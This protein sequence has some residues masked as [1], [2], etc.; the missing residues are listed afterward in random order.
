METTEQLRLEAFFRSLDPEWRTQCQGAEP[1]EI[2][3]LEGAAQ[4]P[5]PGFYRWFLTRMGASMGSFYYRT[6]DFTVPTL[7]AS[8]EE[9]EVERSDRFLL[10]ARSFAP[11]LSLH[12]FYDFDWRTG[13]DARVVVAEEPEDCCSP[14]F[15]SLKDMLCWGFFYSHRVQRCSCRCSGVFVSSEDDV[16]QRL[17]PALS[18]IGFTAP[19]ELSSSC[20]VYEKHG[21]SLVTASSLS[22]SPAVHAFNLGGGTQG[23]LRRILGEIALRSGL[24]VEVL[25]WDPASE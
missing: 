12:A 21:V 2:L 13:E 15:E 16:N 11:N 19:V 25:E 6:K 10:I 24:K 14:Q 18:R 7:I 4:L 17:M 8:Y 23:V 1:E 3:R 9:G 22:G 5:L 20:G